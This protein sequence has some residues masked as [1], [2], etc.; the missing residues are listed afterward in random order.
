VTGDLTPEVFADDCRFRDPTN[1]VSGLSRYLTVGL[2]HV[3]HFSA[4]TT[5]VRLPNTRLCCT[6]TSTCITML[7]PTCRP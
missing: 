6:A 1:D 5:Q 2:Q 7:P 3:V 4:W